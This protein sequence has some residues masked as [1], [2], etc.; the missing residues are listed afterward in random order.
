[1]TA[2]VKKIDTTKISKDEVARAGGGGGEA[3]DD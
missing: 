2:S 1:M 3:S